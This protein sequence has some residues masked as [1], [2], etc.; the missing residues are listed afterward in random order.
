[1]ESE[2]LG[3]GSTLFFTLPLSRC[4]AGTS[5]SKVNTD[6]DA[7][8]VQPAMIEYAAEPLPAEDSIR[9]AVDSSGRSEVGR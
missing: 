1:V 6:R 5:G 7:T 2:G 3:K 4:D 9:T 8:A